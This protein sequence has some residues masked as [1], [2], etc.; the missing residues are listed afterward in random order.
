MNKN[1]IISIHQYTYNHIKGESNLAD[2]HPPSTTNNSMNIEEFNIKKTNKNMQK[3]K[4]K[5]YSFSP[6]NKTV[7]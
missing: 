7:S 6:A 2:D 3:K 4:K 1:K 5:Q